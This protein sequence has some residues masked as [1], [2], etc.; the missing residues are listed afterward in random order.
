MNNQKKAIIIGAGPG[1]LT[2]AHEL[3]TRTDIVPIVLEKSSYMGG[4]SRTVNYKGNRIDIGGHRFFSKSDRVMNWWLEHLPLE[5]DQHPQGQISYQNEHRDLT[6]LKQG[7]RRN[8][9]AVM[10]VRP[11]KSR[12]YYSRKLFDYPIRLSLQTLTNL[13]IFRSTQIVFSY[14]RS[15]MMPIRQVAN[16]EQF[17][18]NRFGRNLYR[19]FFKSYTEK[20]WGV[21][22]DQISAEWGEQRI[23]GLSIRKTIAHMFKTA[24]GKATGVAQKKTETSLIERFLYPKYGPGQMWETVARKVEE[25]GGRIIKNFD[26]T[27]L[28]CQGDRI[29]AVAGT[30][31]AG[32]RLEFTGDYFFSTMPIQELIRSMDASVPSNVREV[33]EGL[34]YRDFVTVGMLLKGLKLAKREKGINLIDD[35]WI[36]IQEPD[37]LVGRLQI[38]NNWSPHLV[39]SADT[40]WIGAEYFCY[41]GDELWTKSD[42]EMASFAVQELAKIGIIDSEEV[43]DSTVLR[44]PKTYPAYFGTYSRFGEL[45]AF[46]DKFSNLFL[47]GRNGMHRYNNQDHS[48]LTAMVSVD[49]IIAG[50][51]SKEAIWDVNTEMEY[52]ESKQGDSSSDVKAAARKAGVVVPQ[53]T[54][55]SSQG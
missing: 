17:F 18:I 11:R 38:F 54:A 47:I 30:D 48:M 21:R 36:Y 50:Q 14:L 26:V 35:N 13:G 5:D 12:I 32:N 2:A 41:E 34:M 28:R 33:S 52:H 23:K 22:C 37:V 53:A 43:I 29:V 20:V 15:A 19:T 6:G 42:R 55:V 8:G 3:L 4:I 31:E 51:L 39:A 7:Q 45:R 10:L 40:V 9:D 27:H 49:N 25:K 16:L 44:M 46:L 24:F 1:G